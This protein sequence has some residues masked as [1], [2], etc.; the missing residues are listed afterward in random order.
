MR[1][2][3]AHNGECAAHLA[4]ELGPGP[5]GHQALED[6]G[7]AEI[8]LFEGQVEPFSVFFPIQ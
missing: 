1:L 2:S 4:F 3:E 5:D 8:E 6:V 7:G